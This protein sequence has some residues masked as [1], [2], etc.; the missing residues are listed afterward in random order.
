MEDSIM[1]LRMDRNDYS[2]NPPM[3]RAVLNG[4]LINMHEACS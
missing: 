2:L 1:Y 3:L 4:Y